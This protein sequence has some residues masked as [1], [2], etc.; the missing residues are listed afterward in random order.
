[1]ALLGDGAF[2]MRAT[3]MLTAVE[4]KLPVIAVVFDNRSLQIE[5]EAMFK[6]YGRESMC[7][8]RIKGENELWG[9]DFAKMAEGMGCG[10][11]R[12]E[13]AADFKP[14]FEAAMKSGKPTVI[15]V[16]TEIETPQ[17]RSAWYP[18]PKDFNATWKPG[19]VPGQVNHGFE[20]PS[21]TKK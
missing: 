17:Y 5:R 18:Y 14:A 2:I 10:G 21:F 4:Q 13:K 3:V 6:I 15:S 8:Y 12:V 20:M 16:A 11:V 7:D 19:P 1:M 9:P